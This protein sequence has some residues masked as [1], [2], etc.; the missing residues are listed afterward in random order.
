MNF[1]LHLSRWEIA[2]YSL[3]LWHNYRI[4]HTLKK[5]G[6][7]VKVDNTFYHPSIF[8]CKSAKKSDLYIVFVCV[9]HE[10]FN[11]TVLTYTYNRK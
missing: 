10:I 5:R 4:S 11:K 6:Y 2:K 3:V 9:C 8:I 1:D 7:A